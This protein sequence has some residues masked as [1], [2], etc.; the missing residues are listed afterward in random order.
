MKVR[1]NIEALE[2]IDRAYFGKDR[3]KKIREII[4]ITQAMLDTKP[5][6]LV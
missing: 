6:D 4:D 3:V 5:I 2:K 1:A